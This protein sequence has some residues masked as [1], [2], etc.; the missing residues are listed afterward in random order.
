MS[1]NL[2]I[3]SLFSGIGGLELGLE[4]AG[5]G[6]TVWHCERDSFARSVLA[7][8]WPDVPRFKDVCELGV[9][10]EVPEVDVM[11]GGFPCQGI[12]IAG[13]GGGLD[14]ERSGLWREFARIIGDAR[15]RYVVLEN[16]PAITSRGLGTV[17]GD[18]AS[19]GYDAWWDCIPAAAVGAPHRRDRWFCIA[20]RAHTERPGRQRPTGGRVP[21]AWG[22]RIQPSRLRRRGDVWP[23][24]PVVGGA[25]DGV[26]TRLDWPTPDAGAAN[27]GE[28]LNKWAARRE[29]VKATAGN[30]N[31]FGE[32]LAAAVRWP[33]PS[34]TDSKDRGYQRSGGRV[35][36][37][38]P[39]SVGG[40]SMPC[41][42]VYRPAQPWERGVPRVVTP[43][44][45]DQRR[46]CLRC[47]GNAVV[48]QVAEVIGGVLLDIHAQVAE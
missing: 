14:D 8:H 36:E 24:Q 42:P 28:D 43:H 27:D 30:G 31:G 47:L 38:L 32:P 20:W 48:P 34:A 6:R 15:P 1:A 39:G 19:R 4:R 10:V 25:A 9:T 7:Q 11:C 40:A 45:G 26:P 13:K 22:P 33:T 16:S 44:K 37:S 5:V 21:P 12:S 3:G 17:L 2:R 18:L 29:R 41:P 23:T 46:A 35:S